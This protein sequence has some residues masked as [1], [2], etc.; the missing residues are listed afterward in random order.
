MTDRRPRTGFPVAWLSF[1]AF[2][3]VLALLAL[4]LREGADPSLGEAA[5]P[6]PQP[7]HV[8]VRRIIRRKVVVHVI[9]PPIDVPTQAAS[10][11]GPTP[12][13][14]G[15]PSSVAAALPRAAAAAPVQA[16]PPVAAPAPPPPAPAPAPAPA[17]VTR[18]S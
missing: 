8:L 16:A 12:V 9:P 14:T 1:S 4:Q 3:V 18:S 11:T 10:P 17:P 5:A 13:A 7:R 6:Q 15:A 2:V